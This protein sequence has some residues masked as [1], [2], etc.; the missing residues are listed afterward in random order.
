VQA[1]A[2][3][4]TSNVLEPAVAVNDLPWLRQV[5]A[6]AVDAIVASRA[7]SIAPSIRARMDVRFM[8]YS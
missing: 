7:T 3:L 1:S 4:P 8:V 5:E 6:P 2:V